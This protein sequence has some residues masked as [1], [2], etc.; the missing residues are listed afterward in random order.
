MKNIILIGYRC[1]GKTTVGKK[2]SERLGLPFIDTD[3]LV[4]LDTGMSVDEIVREG[5]WPLFR[6]KEREVIKGLS[7]ADDVIIAPGGGAIEDPQNR[8]VLRKNGL[9]VWLTA[10]VEIIVERMRSDLKNTDQR[11]PL[12]G[13]DLQAEVMEMTRKREPVYRELADL[14]IDTSHKDIDEIGDEIQRFLKKG[15]GW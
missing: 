12:S 6:Q 10:D 2:L 1:T 15:T 8:E 14:T 9:F 11:P 7:S 4:M 13:G 3:G 5:G